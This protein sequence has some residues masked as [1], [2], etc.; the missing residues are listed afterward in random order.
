MPATYGELASTSAAAVNSGSDGEIA[1]WH[2]FHD[3]EL[4]SLVQRAVSANNSLKLAEARVR[5]ARSV[6]EVAKSLLYPR[7]GVGAS[8]LRFR[9]SQSAIGLP[10]A[11]LEDNLFQVGFDAE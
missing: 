6:R 10:T 4:A 2:R 11:N 7:I 5:Q 9:G 1:W 3:A 8:A